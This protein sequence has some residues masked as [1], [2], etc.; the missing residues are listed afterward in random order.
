MLP[1]FT[2]FVHE[3]LQNVSKLCHG[4]TY[5]DDHRPFIL[6]STDP[7]I[8]TPSYRNLVCGDSNEHVSLKYIINRYHDGPD[9]N[10]KWMFSQ[11]SEVLLFKNE[12]R[13][14]H[15]K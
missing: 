11:C 3:R 13:S 15:Y 2:V 5:T 9:L 10:T 12:V 14:T 6:H 1:E 7:D 8:V 4:T